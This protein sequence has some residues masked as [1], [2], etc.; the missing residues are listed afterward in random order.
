MIGR[1][2]RIAPGRRVELAE[3]E[4]HALDPL[5]GDLRLH[6]HE[7]QARRRVGAGERARV[8]HVAGAERIHVVRVEGEQRPA[9][10]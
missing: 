10:A 7:A 2:T 1:Q 8:L 4:P 6:L 5:A 9:V 3:P